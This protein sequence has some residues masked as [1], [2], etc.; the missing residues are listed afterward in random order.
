[1][2][3]AEASGSF[4]QA[5]DALQGGRHGADS[6]MHTRVRAAVSSRVVGHCQGGP[7]ASTASIHTW[8]SM[9]IPQDTLP[10]LKSVP[11]ERGAGAAER[12][13]FVLPPDI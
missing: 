3:P 13:M 12:S 9:H 4:P 1:M 8:I 10:H 11:S 7:A 6:G 5:A 2:W